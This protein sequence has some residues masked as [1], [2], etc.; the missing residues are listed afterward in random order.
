MKRAYTCRK[1]INKASR[2][3]GCIRRNLS[4]CSVPAQETHNVAT[5]S[6][7]RRCNVTT[8]QR[9]CNDVVRTL[10]VCW[11]ISQPPIQLKFDRYWNTPSLLGTLV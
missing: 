11:E 9:R 7:Q 8:L 2:T 3:L 6:L 4:D 1:P 10:C 5:T